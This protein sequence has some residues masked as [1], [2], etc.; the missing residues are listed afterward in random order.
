MKKFRVTITIENISDTLSVSDAVH[1]NLTN[2]QD[3]SVATQMVLK[4]GGKFS[5]EFVSQKTDGSRELLVRN[6]EL[7]ATMS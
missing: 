7:F 2:S 4:P 5:R 3:E 1:V 6:L